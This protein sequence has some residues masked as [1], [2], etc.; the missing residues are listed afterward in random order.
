MPRRVTVSQTTPVAKRLP[1][2]NQRGMSMREGDY[3]KVA[4]KHHWFRFV[5]Y[6]IRVGEDGKV[7]EGYVEG[8]QLKQKGKGKPVDGGSVVTGGVRCLD[9]SSVRET[10]KRD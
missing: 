8:V 7:R 4:G 3:F 9:P 5:A 6:V 1:V 2:F 10:A